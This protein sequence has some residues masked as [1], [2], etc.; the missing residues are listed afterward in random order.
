M[1]TMFSGAGTQG[2]NANASTAVPPASVI[3]VAAVSRS[4]AVAV[5][6]RSMPTAPLSSRPD[7]VSAEPTCTAS[8]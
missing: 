7:S 3:A 6:N 2:A 4:S 8:R 1:Q 5:S